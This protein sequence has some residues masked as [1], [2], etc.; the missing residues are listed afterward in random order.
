MKNP[1]RLVRNYSPTDSADSPQNTERKRLDQ[2]I[3]GSPARRGRKEAVHAGYWG[4]VVCPHQKTETQLD[5][6][7]ALYVD[8]LP[9]LEF[10]H[11]KDWTVVFEIVLA[12]MAAEKRKPTAYE[13]SRLA[14]AYA[15]ATKD[16][17]A[18]GWKGVDPVYDEGWQHGYSNGLQDGL[19]G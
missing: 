14:A 10:H 3:V 9:T 13:W 17:A 19:D 16:R 18:S 7:D 2:W 4:R 5:Y 15:A 1:D 8:R 11:G 12:N 6:K